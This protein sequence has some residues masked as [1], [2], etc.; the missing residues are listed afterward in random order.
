MEKIAEAGESKCCTPKALSPE[1]FGKVTWVSDE[2]VEHRWAI[3]EPEPNQIVQSESD[4][5]DSGVSDGSSDIH[6][7]IPWGWF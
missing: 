4:L 3:P 2:W 1:N 7:R 5:S 6:N